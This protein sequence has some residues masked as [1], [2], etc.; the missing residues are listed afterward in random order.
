M[1]DAK[2][3]NDHS[4]F[5]VVKLGFE[6][7]RATE[8]D[9]HLIEELSE[10]SH[11]VLATAGRNLKRKITARDAAGTDRQEFDGA[12]EAPNDQ[13]RQTSRD[14]QDCQRIKQ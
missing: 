8:L 7:T 12:G 9:G 5:G 10:L 14:Q 13:A 6:F 3:T 4:F 1:A 2:S 11:F